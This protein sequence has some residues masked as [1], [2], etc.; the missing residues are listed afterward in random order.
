[1]NDQ[2]EENPIPNRCTHMNSIL[3]SGLCGPAAKVNLKASIQTKLEGG[4]TWHSAALF[5]V[6]VE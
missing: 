3:I 2:Q 1:M 5:D 4:K 6:T